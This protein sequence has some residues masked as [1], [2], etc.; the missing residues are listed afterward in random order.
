MEGKSCMKIWYSK[1]NPYVKAIIS[2]IAILMIIIS[3]LLVF[4]NIQYNEY[5]LKEEKKNIHLEV[6][7]LSNVIDKSINNR[8]LLLNG[9]EGFVISNI[10][11][12]TDEVF[13]LFSEGLTS[14]VKELR[15][16]IIAPDGINEFVYPIEGNEEAIG[17][18]QLNDEREDVRESV[19][20]AINSK[21][22]IV[23]GPYE[24]RQG[25]QG[26]IFKKAVFHNG[27]FWGMISEA[28][29][30][31]PI[32]INAG[33]ENYN[34]TLNIAIRSNS[35]IIYGETN[36]FDNDPVISY[37]QLP[38]GQLEVAAI[39]VE[40]WEGA[41][42]SKKN[43]LLY[44]TILVG[45]LL[46]ILVYINNYGKSKL[47]FLVDKKTKQIEEINVQLRT[48]QKLEAIGT[49]ASG[50][51]HE[52]NNP[53]NGILNYGQVILDTDTKD[54]N[55]KE[56]AEEI[57]RESNRIAEIVKNLLSF[58]RN[59]KENYSYVHIED[60]LSQTI[61][62]IKTVLI[63]D[64]IELNISIAENLTKIKCHSQQIR[65]VLLNLLLNS[66]DALNEKFPIY[67]ENKII[68][69]RCT[70]MDRD[71]QKWLKV[72]I[73][74]FGSG[75]PE[76]VKDKIF[77]PFFTTKE[78]NKGTGLGLSISYGIV[79]DH[80]GKLE[81]ESEVNNYTKFTLLLPV[82]TENLL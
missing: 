72:T 19:I 5:I 53:I 3:P 23:S 59:G 56:Y 44:M 33:L 73:E 14:S 76:N 31:E 22:V 74:D 16:V 80:N 63:H 15:N 29:N 75:I 25:G 68:N 11:G 52:I 39:P 24:L 35:E 7:R 30:I 82:E 20:R 78:R 45:A 34:S 71:G 8:I 2:A 6:S 46:F 4:L 18:D 40:G 70:Q 32:F 69:I 77:D 43:L 58:S 36:I 41:I 12:I 48:S 38:Q 51:A 42:E 1:L 27:I 26:I 47:V 79:K 37:V 60:I 50:V 21:E 65:Q 61:K 57:I 67:N 54:D 9:L 13:V 10:D 62:L 28:L 64:R 81:I 66:Q 17:H 49:L 55:I